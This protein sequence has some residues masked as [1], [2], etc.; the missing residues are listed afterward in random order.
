MEIRAIDSLGQ[1]HQREGGDT[2][3]T[4][5]NTVHGAAHIGSGGTQNIQ[6][7]NQLVSEIIPQL[8]AF[9]EAIKKETFDDKDDVIR[10][11][12]VALEV[13]KSNPAATSNDGT[14]KRIQAKLTAANTTME[15]AKLT[16][17]T[18]PFWPT[19]WAFFFS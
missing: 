4:N 14:W 3:H 2:Y 12:E 17:A 18:H 19:I 6:V 8:A 5:I 7:N 10:D 11:L 15:I 1:S 13:A 16:Y 9:V